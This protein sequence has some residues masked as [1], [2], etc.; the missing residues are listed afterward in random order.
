VKLSQSLDNYIEGDGAADR[1]LIGVMSKITLLLTVVAAFAQ[2][3]FDPYQ[4]LFA[5]KDLRL[6]LRAEG[7]AYAGRIEV[8]GQ[9][10][11][12]TGRVVN[13]QLAAGFVSGGNRFA[14][15]ATVQN[16]TMRLVS[17]GTEYVLIRQGGANPL[18]ARGAA[19]HVHPKGFSVQPAA[20]WTARDN[21]QGVLLAPAG[22]A[23]DEVYVA[24]LQDGY[25]QAEEAKTVRELSQAF[26]Q[27]VRDIRRN[28]ERQAIGNG[29]AYYWEMV[30]PQ[31]GKVAGL[32]I[33]FVP[34]GTQANVI[35]A[36]GAAQRIQPRDQDLRQMLA[37][38]QTAAAQP[39]AAG[40]LADSTAAAQQWLAKLKGKM[41]RQFHTYQGMSSDKRHYL[42]AD[43]TYRF[44]SSSMVS[45]D[46]SGA[47]GLS[48][49]SNGEQGRWSI[50][51]V[52]GQVYLKIQYRDGRTGQYRLTRDDRNWYMNG[53]KAFAVEPE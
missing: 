13:G 20:G 23:D 2:G 31:T 45:V 35:V 40:A 44:V 28:G 41:I 37:S 43:G 10:F 46:V 21:E 26:L 14:F 39:M 16:N 29:A 22:A 51:E 24:A 38:M 27:N 52:G 25:S 48:T 34:R 53:E 32:K 8:Q 9:A 6:E 5:G 18:A 49:G 30:D 3:G 4:G 1:A 36:F 17:D 50:G 7:G 42:N 47:S 11:P 33:Y 15:Q 19:A 12:V